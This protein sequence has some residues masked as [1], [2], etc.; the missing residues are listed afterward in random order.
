VRA[1]AGLPCP[2]VDP[3]NIV[4]CTTAPGEGGTWRHI[5]ELGAELQHRGHHV[6]VAAGNALRAPAESE[7]LKWLAVRQALRLRDNAVWHFHLHD[8]YDPA[9]AVIVTLRSMAGPVVVTEH[10]PRTDA[11]DASLGLPGERRLTASIIAKTLFK[12][13]QYNRVDSLLTVSGGAA[14]FMET[15]YG[16]PKGR[17]CVV[18][19][20]VPSERLGRPKV[21]GTPVNVLAIGSAIRQKGFDILLDAAELSSGWRVTFLGGGTHLDELRTVA[22]SLP[23]GRATFLGRQ[24]D[25]AAFLEAADIVCVPSRWESSSYVALEAGLAA[26]PVVAADVDGVNEI[27]LDARTGR[28]VRAGSPGAF[29]RALNDIVSSP[30]ELREWGI[31][32]QRR[33]I[34]EFSLDRMVDGICASYERAFW[35]RAKTRA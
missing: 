21:P 12:R 25:T 2:R 3:M 5:R 14:A 30:H 28:L 22:A 29:A 18:Q 8:T 31:A 24:Q 1:V 6:L 7:G 35:R 15:R 16:L 26:R 13:L 23:P 20:G 11:S 33:V 17:I 9:A 27:V 34:S 10:L 19:N 4:L 32:G